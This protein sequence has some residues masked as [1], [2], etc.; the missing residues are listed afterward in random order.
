MLM[1][2]RQPGRWACIPRRLGRWLQQRRVHVP[3]S[4][5]LL[6]LLNPLA[7]VIHCHLITTL[8]PSAPVTRL[9]GSSSMICG[10]AAD[11]PVAP[12]PLAPDL[13]RTLFQLVLTR[14][15]L[16]LPPL[17]LLLLR[18]RQPDRLLPQQQDAPI[19]PP[20]RC[21]LAHAT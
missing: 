11:A 3:A 6:L 5:L 15:S 12:P 13:L 14:V 18:W 20:P 9:A 1:S 4:L 17:L 7:C 21:L 16:L 10:H 19:P 2:L 8:T